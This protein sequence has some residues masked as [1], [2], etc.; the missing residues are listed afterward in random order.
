M[1]FYLGSMSS[2]PKVVVYIL[3]ISV[4]FTANSSDLGRTI[5]AHVLTSFSVANA[6]LII[7]PSLI[8]KASLAS[9]MA[10][11]DLLRECD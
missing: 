1:N 11:Q 6:E 3:S 5:L 7:N 10:L 8:L 9:R 2:N 4:I